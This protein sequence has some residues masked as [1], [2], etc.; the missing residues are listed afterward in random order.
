MKRFVIPYVCKDVK[1]SFRS[2][3]DAKPGGGGAT[4][5]TASNT[6]IHVMYTSFTQLKRLQTTSSFALH[7]RD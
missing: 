7:M 3:H 6:S 5:A 1:G 4:T 2:V